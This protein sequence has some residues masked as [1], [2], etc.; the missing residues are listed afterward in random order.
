LKKE[1]GVRAYIIYYEAR[2]SESANEYLT[3]YR[4][5]KIRNEIRSKTN[6]EDEDIVLEAIS[7]IV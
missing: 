2:I 5:E 3:S 1:R 7:K 6:L 4:R